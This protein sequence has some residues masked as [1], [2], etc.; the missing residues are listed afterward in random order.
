[1]IKGKNPKRNCTKFRQDN[2][3]LSKTE[4]GQTTTHIYNHEDK[5]DQV[6]LPNGTAIAYS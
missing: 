6:N 2:Y 5:M 1:M 3:V 4:N